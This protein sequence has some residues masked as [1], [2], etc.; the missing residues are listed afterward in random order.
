MEHFRYINTM[1]KPNG[2]LRDWKE[3]DLLTKYECNVDLFAMGRGKDR[4]P[5]Q[6]ARKIIDE[7]YSQKK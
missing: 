1:R 7:E 2:E 3:H 5:F 6:Q 4:Y